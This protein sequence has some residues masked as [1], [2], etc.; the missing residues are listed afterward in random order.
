MA[1]SSEQA[2]YYQNEA[3]AY[4]GICI[5]KNEYLLRLLGLLV[6]YAGLPA[7]TGGFIRMWK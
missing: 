2:Q 4:Y 6:Y 1:K 3:S 5:F 7:L